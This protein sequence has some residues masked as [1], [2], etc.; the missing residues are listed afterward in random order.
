MNNLNA[1]I[2]IV[3]MWVDGNDPKW[4]KKKQLF[5][6]TP[7]DNSEMNNI[8]RYAN[9]DELKYSLRSVEK[10]APWIRNIF[11]VTDD[12]KPE[13]LNTNN[14]KIRVIDHTEIL[15][16]AVLP[17][18]NSS[19][20]EYYLHKI[21][22]LSEYFLFANDDMFFNADLSPDFFFAKDGYPIVR[23]KRKIFGKFHHQIK[24]MVSDIGHYRKM[25]IESMQLVEQKFGIFFSGVPHHNIDSFRKSD[26]QKAMEEVFNE[27]VISSHHHRTRTFGDF[28]RSALSYYALAIN[29]AH[30]KYI[31]R[32]EA[33][34]IFI[35]KLNFIKNIERY[36]PLLF[37]L[38]DNEH[39]TDEHRRHVAPFLEILFPQKSIFEK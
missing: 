2:D 20:I 19:V 4:R 31:D 35:S 13:W 14:S 15:P 5:T 30:L 28:H 36:K 38:N 8:G 22:G 12:Q 25:V 11:I 39:A 7:S 33:Y 26:Y 32:K 1:E 6:N 23:L 29:H 17:T 3:Y 37:C 27:Q 16:P 24:A 9:S 18:F 34:R 10:H 21:P